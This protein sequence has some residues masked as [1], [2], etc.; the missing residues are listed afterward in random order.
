[1]MTEMIA[2]KPIYGVGY[3]KRNPEI[4]VYKTVAKCGQH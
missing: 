2:M 4:L 3:R 1:M